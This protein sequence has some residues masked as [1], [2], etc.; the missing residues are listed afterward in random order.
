MGLFE[1]LIFLALLGLIAWALT[2]YIPMSS[3]IAR[4]IQIVAVVVGVWVVLGAFG[5]LPHDVPVPRIR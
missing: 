2:R 5:L 4:L 3:G 1:L